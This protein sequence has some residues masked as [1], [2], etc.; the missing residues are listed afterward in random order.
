MAKKNDSGTNDESSIRTLG[1][2]ITT[3]DNDPTI[4]ERIST[5]MPELG[6]MKTVHDR[7][8]AL[9]AE[10]LGGNREKEG[11]L[12]AARMDTNNHL[13]VFHGLVQLT[14]SRD[15]SIPQSL[16]ITAPTPTKRSLT[17][18]FSSPEN[19]RLVYKGLS[20]IARAGSVKGAKNYE[21]WVCDGDPMVE[22]NWRYH[23]HSTR[24][25][26]IEITG[27][28]PGR[29]YYFRIRAVLSG[30]NSPWSNFVGMMAI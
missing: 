9:F 22:S 29:M 2:L 27:L 10:V 28:T 4:L 3:L 19:L 21:I 5:F 1:E 30:G 13:G 6:K 17:N 16:G 8:R 12:D 25:N 18:H 23:S 7:H 26:H 20:L 24:V 11:E 15:P 14:G